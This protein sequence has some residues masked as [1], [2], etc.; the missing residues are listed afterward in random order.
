MGGLLL[1]C[2]EPPPPPPA[3]PPAP[4][5]AAAPASALPP[6]P[7]N[8]KTA[9]TLSQ[10]ARARLDSGHASIHLTE[11]RA[12]LI[13]LD[14]LRTKLSVVERGRGTFTEAALA[15]DTPEQVDVT[16]NGMLYSFEEEVHR[17]GSK[18]PTAD[19]AHG[20]A[21]SGGRLLGGLHTI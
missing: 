16:L 9:S 19:G 20:I 8:E 5:T 14:G 4:T 10:W 13:V 17:L 7:N 18:R 12:H 6:L 2:Q 11:G 3:E 21:V 15:E 1:A